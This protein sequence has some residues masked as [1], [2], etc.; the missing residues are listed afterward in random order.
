MV[1][2]D[3]KN[4]GKSNGDEVAQLYL[5]NLSAKVPVPIRSLK[6]FKRI[7]LNPGEVK[8]VHF[9]IPADAFSVIDEQNKKVILPGEY[10]IS[11]GGQQPAGSNDR[12]IKQARIK[13]H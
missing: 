6:G 9:T 13:I 3:V 12:Q 2:V 8:T 10:S 11:V 7:N 1:S 4:T 5:S